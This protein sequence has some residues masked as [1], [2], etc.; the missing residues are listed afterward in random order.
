MIDN[1]LFLRCGSEETD[2]QCY[3]NILLRYKSF[4]TKALEYKTGLKL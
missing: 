4:I 2:L 1:Y 3:S